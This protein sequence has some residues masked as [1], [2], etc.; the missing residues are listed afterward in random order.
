[1]AVGL[2]MMDGNFNWRDRIG[3]QFK[4]QIDALNWRL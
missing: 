1:M 2:D 4:E 3:Y